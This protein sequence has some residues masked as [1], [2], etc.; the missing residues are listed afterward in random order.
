MNEPPTLP[1]LMRETMTLLGITEMPELRREID[2]DGATFWH[3]VVPHASMGITIERDPAES[4]WYIVTD[5]TMG[6][7]AASGNLEETR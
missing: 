7:F 6:R 2:D 4:G 5:K 3:C 1:A